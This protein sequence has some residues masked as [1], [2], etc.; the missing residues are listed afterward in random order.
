MNAA[1]PCAL[2][3]RALGAVSRSSPAVLRRGTAV[4][5]GPDASRL[6]PRRADRRRGCIGT[7]FCLPAAVITLVGAIDDRFP[8]S[9]ARQA[10]GQIAAAVVA[11]AVRGVVG[12]ARSRLPLFGALHFPQCRADAE[13]H[14]ARGD[15]ERRQLSRWRGRPCG[16]GLRANHRRRVR[17]IASISGQDAARRARRADRRCIARLSRAQLPSRFE[18]HGRL[19]APTCSDC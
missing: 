2:Q 8:T 9:P 1:W 3:P 15:D 7:A 12:V 4:A 5:A 14:L 13:R 11:A 17:V 18:L 6:P 16:G 10:L 19:R